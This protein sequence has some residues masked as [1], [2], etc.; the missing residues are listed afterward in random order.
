MRVKIQD[1][2]YIARLARLQVDEDKVQRISQKM[3]KILD[4]MSK[5]ESLDYGEADEL[6]SFEPQSNIFREDTVKVRISH[7]EA[8]SE[9]PNIDSDYYRVPKVIG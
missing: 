4:Y 3:S 8:L 2:Y 1:V 5:L 7:D 9:S 6:T